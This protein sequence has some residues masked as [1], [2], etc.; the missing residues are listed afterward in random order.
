MTDEEYLADCTE[1][2]S[3]SPDPS[4][5]TGAI[6]VDAAGA[7]TARGR[8]H[9]SYGIACTEVRLTRPAKY[10]WI[11]HAERDA[12]YSAARRGVRTAGSDM[13]L[14]WYPCADCAR[15]II[16]AGISKLICRE[17]DWADPRWSEDF[18][19]VREMLAEAE[20]AVRF[21]GKFEERAA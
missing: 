17:P 8:N 7:V 4:R 14:T 1:Y 20:I 12:I 6:I 15:G 10:K 3:R 2:A 13:Y 18:A 9:F 11:E 16:Q 5:K 21:V 19:I